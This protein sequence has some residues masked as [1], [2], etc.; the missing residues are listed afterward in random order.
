MGISLSS[1]WHSVKWNHFNFFVFFLVWLII[2]YMF[3]CL[4]VCGPSLITH[5]FHCRTKNY[6]YKMLIIKEVLQVVLI[7]ITQSLYITQCHT[8]LNILWE[9]WF[10][11]QINLTKK[12]LLSS[13]HKN[14]WESVVWLLQ[15]RYKEGI[16]SRNRVLK[17]QRSDTIQVQLRK[18]MNLLMLFIYRCMGDSGS[19]IIEWS[20]LI[21][22]MKH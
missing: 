10:H 19:C 8:S 1:E 7:T 17:N 4:F 14:R 20:Y 16:I 13:V 3:V 11:K 15:G 5:H 22:V 9:R 2:I 12:M 21:W 18:P 6:A